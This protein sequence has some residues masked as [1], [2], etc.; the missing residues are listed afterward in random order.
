MTAPVPAANNTNRPSSASTMCIQK[1]REVP[2]PATACG[3][4]RSRVS[5]VTRPGGAHMALA[6]MTTL[7]S[8]RPPRGRPGRSLSPPTHPP[9]PARHRCGWT[10][11]ARTG[12]GGRLAALRDRRRQGLVCQWPGIRVYRGTYQR[13][14][15]AL[16]LGHRRPALR[17]PGA[18]PRRRSRGRR[19]VH[20]PSAP[21]NVRRT[22]SRRR[23]G[24]P[25]PVPQEQE[26]PITHH[27]LDLDRNFEQLWAGF[28]S[29]AR[30]P[31][32]RQKR[33]TSPSRSAMA[34]R[35]FWSS[36]ASTRGGSTSGRALEASHYPWPAGWAGR[37]SRYPG[38]S[39]SPT[40]SGRRSEY[41]LPE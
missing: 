37:T 15:H 39:P 29:A 12:V 22:S 19:S 5:M 36:T 23:C 14:F 17:R 24:R 25:R 1:F 34:V 38:C 27:V 28:S 9:F 20:R 33:S 26:L 21:D 2:L 31:S 32:A 30:A 35:R 8:R 16:H 13:R 3:A 4:R 11:C 18:R 41:G 40:R 10:L 7:G 6:S